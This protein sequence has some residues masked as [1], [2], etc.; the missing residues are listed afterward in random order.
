MVFSVFKSPHPRAF[1]R[2]R[3]NEQR[4]RRPTPHPSPSPLSAPRQSPKDY[5]G[6]PDA[7]PPLPA[8]LA[9]ELL[10]PGDSP[11]RS[12]TPGSVGSGSRRDSLASVATVAARQ[13]LG[14]EMAHHIVAEAEFG[15]SNPAAP[16]WELTHARARANHHPRASAHDD[17]RRGG[18]RGVRAHGG[19]GSAAQ[20][21]SR[22]NASSVSTG[23]M[24]RK[25]PSG[26]RRAGEGVEEEEQTVVDSEW[27]PGGGLQLRVTL[28]AAGFVIGASGASVREITQHTGAMIQS[29]T[30]QPQPGR[31]HRPTR[32]F[33][34]TGPRKSV[35]AASEIVHQAV[36]RYKELCEGKR[37]GEFV[38]RQ[39]RI[40]GVEFSYQPPPRSAAPQAAAL[41]GGRLLQQHHTGGGGGAP[42]SALFGAPF[43]APA[44]AHIGHMG[45]IPPGM[46]GG[47]HMG[48]AGG[49]DASRLA[50]F[51]ASGGVV[52]PPRSSSDDDWRSASTTVRRRC[53]RS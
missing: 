38:Q 40:R 31:Y 46:G 10:D 17:H 20:A 50:M 4:S 49:V 11:P 2:L 39:Q 9:A 51:A 19:G 13:S 34:V 1:S 36:E 48:G 47:Y 30:Q 29:W 43:G 15:W 22:A 44:M 33:R 14:S 25:G 7:P 35:A 28:L 41:G 23:A 24:A 52:P 53:P 16:A 6:I 8:D 42:A 18:G 37:R 27:L 5:D 3:A 26:P 21:H 12:S 32:V 45:A